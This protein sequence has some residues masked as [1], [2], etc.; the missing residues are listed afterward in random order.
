ML[1]ISIV[2]GIVLLITIVGG[3]LFPRDDSY[4]D[5]LP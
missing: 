4:D 5:D 2:F 1:A 3:I